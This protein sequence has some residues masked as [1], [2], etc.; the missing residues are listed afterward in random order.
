MTNSLLALGN[1][2]TDNLDPQ[3]AELIST[4]ALKYSSK[5]EQSSTADE[6]MWHLPINVFILLAILIILCIFRGNLQKVIMPQRSLPIYNASYLTIL[7]VFVLNFIV[8]I[9]NF[10]VIYY[11]VVA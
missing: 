10:F 9:F 11:R 8:P 6:V 2:Q 7:K 1:L 4:L 5:D 3:L